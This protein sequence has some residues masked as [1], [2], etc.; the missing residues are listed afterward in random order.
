M[1]A[2]FYMH[3]E[4]YWKRIQSHALVDKVLDSKNLLCD[5]QNLLLG[6]PQNKANIDINNLISLR[7]EVQKEDQTRQSIWD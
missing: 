5:K 1:I 4:E 3:H 2:Y 6:E 7:G